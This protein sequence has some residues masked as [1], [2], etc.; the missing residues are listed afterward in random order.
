MMDS[1]EAEATDACPASIS[2]IMVRIPCPDEHRKA[3][4][5]CNDGRRLSNEASKPQHTSYM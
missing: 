5:Y 2:V 4:A 1:V 3:S